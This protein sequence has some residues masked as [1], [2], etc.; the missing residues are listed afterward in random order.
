MTTRTIS[1]DAAQYFTATEDQ[2]EL[3]N[4]ALSQ[5]DPAYI[6]VAL[7]TVTRAQ[8]LVDRR[9]GGTEEPDIEA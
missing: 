2:V 6:A 8:N 7:G 9:D 4:D 1:F 5:G 3:L